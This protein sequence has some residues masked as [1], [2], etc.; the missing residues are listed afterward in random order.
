MSRSQ[1]EAAQ[2]EAERRKLEALLELHLKAAKLDKLFVREYAAVKG[3]KFRWDFACV[4]PDVRLLVEVQGGIWRKGGHTSGAGVT[5][6]CAKL[7]AA[8]LAGWRQLSF[9]G[10]MIESGQALRMIEQ[11]LEEV[12]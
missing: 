9:T 4:K 5:R 8:T 11:F 10:E 7:N 1:L 6:D 3:R 12:K 2:L